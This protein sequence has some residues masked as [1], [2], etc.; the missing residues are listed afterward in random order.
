MNKP[1]IV[2][3]TAVTV[4][5][6]TTAVAITPM[7][8][9]NRAV[10]SGADIDVLEKLMGLQERWEQNEAKRAYNEAIAAAR[11]EIPPIK[12]NRHVGFT[13]KRTQTDTSYD[14][15]DLAEIARTVDP[16]LSRHGLSY[17]WRTTSRP[18]E[19]VTVTCIVSHRL[20]YS[21]EN[22]LSGPA[23][24]SGNKNPL[25]GIGS[26]CTFLQ[27]YTLK[28][29]LGIAAANDDDGRAAGDEVPDGR[30]DADQ[31]QNIRDKLAA[32][33]ASEA[34]FLKWAKV[35]RIEDVA[36]DLYDSCCDAILTFKKAPAAS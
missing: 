20:G 33:G 4:H 26:A 1:Q 32:V 2:D 10:S 29:A 5:E 15:E 12:K 22:T 24:N 36:A 16:I 23:D 28:A 6:Q 34:K 21:E 19:P 17:R 14:H 30:I 13:S 7:D 18:N 11:A 27:R 31:A 25:Q 8:M 9:L 3:S 35:D